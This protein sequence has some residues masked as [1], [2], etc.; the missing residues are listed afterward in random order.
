[1]SNLFF[2]F[3]FSNVSLSSQ[4]IRGGAAAPPSQRMWR[5]PPLQRWEEKGGERSTGNK[6]EQVQREG[7]FKKKGKE[8]NNNKLTSKYIQR[9][10][11]DINTT[12][13]TEENSEQ[14]VRNETKNLTTKETTGRH[15]K[16]E[17]T[18]TKIIGTTGR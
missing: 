2:F 9:K 12:R 3:K 7:Q 18:Q 8:R 10:V 11:K 5:A 13:T 4:P 6:K 16:T 17:A 1:M 14:K 15:A